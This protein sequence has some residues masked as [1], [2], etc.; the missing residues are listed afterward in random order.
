MREPSTYWEWLGPGVG[1][2]DWNAGASALG[3][4][5]LKGPGTLTHV[6]LGPGHGGSLFC[7]FHDRRYV[8][9]CDVNMSWR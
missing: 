8:E 7:S 9:V 1:L 5:H 6:G 3:L 4:W 2:K